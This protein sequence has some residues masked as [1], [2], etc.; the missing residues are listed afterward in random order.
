MVKNR[1]VCLFLFY[2]VVNATMIGK[3]MMTTSYYAEERIFLIGIN[4]EAYKIT[5]DFI[6]L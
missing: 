1:Y 6:V 2:L 5:N 4:Y 3:F